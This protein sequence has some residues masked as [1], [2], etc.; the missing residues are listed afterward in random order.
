MVTVARPEGATIV[1]GLSL[2]SGAIAAKT[3]ICIRG[4]NVA[5]LA[6]TSLGS[7]RFIEKPGSILFLLFLKVTPSRK[8]LSYHPRDFRNL[9]AGLF[10]L[11]A[12]DKQT[13]KSSND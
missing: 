1:T 7:F 11:P 4:D 3:N 2:G 12:M 5:I 10:Y 13:G 6:F 9:V 8:S